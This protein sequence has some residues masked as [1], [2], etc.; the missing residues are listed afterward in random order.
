M[1]WMSSERPRITHGHAR[2]G[3]GGVRGFQM[4]GAIPFL[5]I[6]TSG[7]EIEIEYGT[8][9]LIKHRVLN[10]SLLLLTFL[11]FLRTL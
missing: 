5:M 11:T 10:I 1:R 3:G 7:F 2:V 9:P 4:S 8:R 6:R